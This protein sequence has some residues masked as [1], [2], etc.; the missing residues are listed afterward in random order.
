MPKFENNETLFLKEDHKILFELYNS[1]KSYDKLLR[2][3]KTRGS[4]IPEPLTEG[5]V[6]Y[7]FGYKRTGGK[8]GDGINRE[9]KIMEAKSTSIKN[10]CTSF[11][12]KKPY[13]NR[14]YFLDFY[15]SGSE[16]QF[17][18]YDLSDIDFD[19]LNISKKQTFKNQREQGRR[20]RFSIRSEV[21]NKNNISPK[22]DLSLK[23]IAKHFT[24]F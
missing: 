10:D 22:L 16:G 8:T 21:I 13:W 4:N 7:L 14:I 18:I 23:N 12:P 15:N 20:P 1:W 17:K 19:N 5:L 11:S 6:C 2:K 3:F 24:A 9:G